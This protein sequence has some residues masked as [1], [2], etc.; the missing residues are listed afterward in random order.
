ML[1][2]G[3]SPLSVGVVVSMHARCAAESAQD[4]TYRFDSA[5]PSLPRLREGSWTGFLD[6]KWY[7]DQISKCFQARNP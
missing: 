1:M 3:S 5:A 4:R 7:L 2:S 6:R